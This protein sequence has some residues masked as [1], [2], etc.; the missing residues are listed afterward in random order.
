MNAVVQSEGGCAIEQESEGSVLACQV[1][2]N[3]RIL[4]VIA[5]YGMRNMRQLERVIANYQAMKFETQI[6]VL[7]DRP[8]VLPSSVEIVCGLPNGDP[9][10]LPFGHRQ[11]F[12]DRLDQF[13]LFIY[14]EDDMA[15]T[16][17]NLKA[18]LD[19][20]TDLAPDEI[21]G[22]LRYESR[23]D[24]SRSI[25]EAHGTAHWK[26]ETL[27]RRKKSIVAE[28]SNEHAAFYVLNRSQLDQAIESGG[29]LVPPH[30]GA[31][32]MLCSAATDAYTS[33]GFRKVICLHRMEDFL[34]HHMTNQY[35]G[36]LGASWAD[37]KREAEAL[38]DAIEHGSMPAESSGLETG[39]G[40]WA[41]CYDDKCE[42]VMRSIPHGN[43]TVLSLGA[44]CG[45]E[46]EC[47]QSRGAKVT[48][49]PLGYAKGVLL[50]DRGV[51]VVFGS[52]ESLSS[53]L[54]NRE[55]DF[56]VAS[57]LLHLQENA[58]EF[59]QN[60]AA[61]L[62]Q[63]GRLVLKGPNFEFLPLMLKRLRKPDGGVRYIT[64][65]AVRQWV[66]NCGLEPQSV[67]WINK[68]DHGNA[69]GALGSKQRLRNWLG[70]TIL[71]SYPSRY[72]SD[73]WLLVA[74]KIA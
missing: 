71:R 25:P 37:F 61:R 74:E 42:H 28:F 39:S 40:Q 67:E 73:H 53:A 45:A 41:K 60:C 43:V 10:S 44:G 24:G 12:A 8:K 57:G 63:G 65:K 46:E 27:Q 17:A 2:S 47:W 16:E 62:K 13:D 21:A 29:F 68:P 38:K 64:M 35:A 22:Y 69:S 19:V 30:E 70:R 55:F 7:S 34:V 66:A 48:A 4:V 32:D 26:E 50:K 31:Y 9:W 14:S 54:A 36:Q 6:V 15:V 1:P 3:T 52:L 5:S 33:C 56:V 59:L 11:I 20:S 23:S 49:L 18:F 72:T 58:L 51:D